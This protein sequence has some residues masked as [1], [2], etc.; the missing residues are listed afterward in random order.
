M[1]KTGRTVDAPPSAND[2]HVDA[3]LAYVTVEKGLAMNTV[4]AYGRDLAGL[5][6]Y[7]TAQGVQ[8]I[9]TTGSRHLIGFLTTL[10]DRGLSARSQARILTTLRRF[11]RFL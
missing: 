9:R 5:C 3:F 11:Y 4:E 2:A 10:R 8:D 1:I 7:L 6:R